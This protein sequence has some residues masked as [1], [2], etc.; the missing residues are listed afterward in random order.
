MWQME[1]VNQCLNYRLR[2]PRLI[3]QEVVWAWSRSGG[4][5][6]D[7]IPSSAAKKNKKTKKNFLSAQRQ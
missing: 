1:D 5:R 2:A 7:K 3:G 4:D 6:K